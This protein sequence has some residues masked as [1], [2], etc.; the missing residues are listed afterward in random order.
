VFI[1]MALAGLV[2]PALHIIGLDKAGSEEGLL[3]IESKETYWSQNQYSYAYT[4]V[5][6]GHAVRLQTTKD[7]E[8]NQSY[9][10]IYDPENPSDLV[11]G[12]KAESFL[13]LYM[14][15]GNPAVVMICVVALPLLIWGAWRVRPGRPFAS[16]TK[17]KPLPLP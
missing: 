11:F 14:R 2:L 17:Y 10:V 1:L 3:R 5:V 8:E 9:S 12:E 7:L 4:G 15:E 13:L 6:A 16:Q